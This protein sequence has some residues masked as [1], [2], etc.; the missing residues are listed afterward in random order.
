MTPEEARLRF[1]A[2]R[3]ARLA[4]ANAAGQPHLVPLVFA[5]EGDRVFSV[6]DDKP[7]RSTH[8]R[9]MANVTENPHVSLLVDY[10]EDDWSAIW[11]VRADGTARIRETGSAAAE[12]AIDLLAG[13]YEQYRMRRPRGSVL[14]VDVLGW[15][16]WSGSS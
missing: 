11:W 13:R 7:K 5:V 16:G 9:R 4:T 12:A 8:L 1:A 14:E 2:A 6:V 15:S 3:V 10:Y